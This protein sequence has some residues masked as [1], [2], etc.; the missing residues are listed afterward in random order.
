MFSRSILTAAILSAFSAGALANDITGQVTDQQGNPVAGAKV[1]VEGSRKVV[2][3]DEQGRYTL[4]DVPA[5]DVHIHV[6]SDNYLHG[7]KDLGPVTGNPE[8]NFTLSASSVENI[9]VTAT[10]M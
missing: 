6:S 2:T 1:T 3:T 9:L 5:E 10:A 4:V 7:D 8:V